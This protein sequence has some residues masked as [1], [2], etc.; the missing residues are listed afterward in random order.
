LEDVASSNKKY[1]PESPV[2]FS[3]NI[4]QHPY[5]DPALFSS[6][7]KRFL[8]SPIIIPQQISDDG[9]MVW[10]RAYSPLLWQWGITKEAFFNFTD[11]YNEVTKVRSPFVYNNDDIQIGLDF[12]TH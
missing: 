6:V 7:S 9:I 2:S 8:P 1:A 3:H 11:R 4:S 10:K 5:L 12:S